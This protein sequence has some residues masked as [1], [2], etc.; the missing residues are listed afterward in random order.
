LNIV[1]LGL[2]GAGKGTQA[3]K[4]AGSRGL[5]QITTGD[6]FRDN[7]RRETELGLQAKPFYESGGLVP[8]EIT[9]GML[10]S[11]LDAPDCAGG[12]LFDGFPRTLAQAAA[13]DT[14]LNA[15]DGEID[16]VLYIEVPEEE[17]ISRVS[18]RRSCRTC[19]AVYHELTSPPEKLGVCDRCGGELYQRDDDKEEV[20]RN[21]LLVNQ[22]QIEQLLAHYR[23]QG[24][25]QVVDGNRDI[26]SVNRDLFDALERR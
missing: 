19:G 15:K 16:R 4:I 25:L 1:L 12:C 7:I 17:L 9:I 3:A 23:K 11:R 22:E 6:L 21:R 5:V 8:D 14:A 10:L 2:P 24:K 18:G 26:E 13:L 20:V